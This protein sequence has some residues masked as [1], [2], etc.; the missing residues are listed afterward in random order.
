MKELRVRDDTNIWFGPNQKAWVSVS[1]DTVRDAPAPRVNSPFLSLSVSF[2]TFSGWMMCMCMGMGS[3]LL[4][5]AWALLET[6]LQT[7]SRIPFHQ[8]S[9][10]FLP[11]FEWYINPKCAFRCVIS[12]NRKSK[13]VNNKNININLRKFISKYIEGNKTIAFGRLGTFLH[14]G[15]L[16]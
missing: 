6:L 3:S 14:L 5:L 15:H 13:K 7:F 9:E 4:G 2:R 10:P 12:H 16:I 8:V 11:Q 1:R